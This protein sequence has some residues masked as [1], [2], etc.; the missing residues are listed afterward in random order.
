MA[1]INN[2]CPRCRWFSPNAEDWPA[3]DGEL[4][5]VRAPTFS[6]VGAGDPA[7]VRDAAIHAAVA[8]RIAAA[9]NSDSTCQERIFA[10]FFSDEFPY[11]QN[12]SYY[13]IMKQLGPE[14]TREEVYSAIGTLV[15]EGRLEM[16]NESDD[17]DDEDD[18]RLRAVHHAHIST[19]T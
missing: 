1:P 5:A 8:A 9:A 7:A 19:R 3:W 10:I 13:Y 17:E 6:S 4:P 16:L 15:D 2:T 12:L 18:T 14:F 11:D